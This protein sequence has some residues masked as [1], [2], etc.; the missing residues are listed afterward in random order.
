MIDKSTQIVFDRC[1]FVLRLGLYQGVVKS[2]AVLDLDGIDGST[3]HNVI[4]VYMLHFS[5]GLL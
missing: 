1:G 4:D 2:A 3:V 5:H